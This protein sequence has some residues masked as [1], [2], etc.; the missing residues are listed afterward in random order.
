MLDNKIFLN[1]EDVE[2]DILTEYQTLCVSDDVGS[3]L[4]SAHHHSVMVFLRYLID[5]LSDS[6]NTVRAM[7]IVLYVFGRVHVPDGKV[8]VS[9]TY[10]VKHI[11]RLLD[12]RR[13][14][15]GV[16]SFV[17]LIDSAVTGVLQTDPA[18]V[19]LLTVALLT[20]R[21]GRSETHR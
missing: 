5:E 1:S 8:W 15:Q 10:S 16:F 13:C 9:S 11:L 18:E 20:R 21:I 17:G 2:E 4:E 19:E 6:V 14:C 7:D 12:V 3:V